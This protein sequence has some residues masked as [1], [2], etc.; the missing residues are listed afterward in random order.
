MTQKET[1]KSKFKKPPS[2][3]KPNGKNIYQQNRALKIRKAEQKAANCLYNQAKDSINTNVMIPGPTLPIFNKTDYTESKLPIEF[4]DKPYNVGQLPDN[5]QKN[6][7]PFPTNAVKSDS[8]GWQ[9][10]PLTYVQGTSLTGQPIDPQK[11][12]HNNMVPFFGGK[13]NK[14]LIN[15]LIKPC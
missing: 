15:M 10:I 9:G 14:M 7:T 5:S 8:G 1:N 4:K 3:D 13:V 6:T 12:R 11:F 2:W